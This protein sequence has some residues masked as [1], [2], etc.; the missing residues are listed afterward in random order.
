MFATI[1]ACC[2]DDKK[3]NH[4]HDNKPVLRPFQNV[5]LAIINQCETETHNYHMNFSISY[6]LR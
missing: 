6:L 4:I 5:N 1:Q 2:D 3:S